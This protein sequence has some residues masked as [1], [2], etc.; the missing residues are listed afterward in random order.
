VCY[1]EV[2]V[3]ARNGNFMRYFFCEVAAGNPEHNTALYC[4]SSNVGEVNI[5]CQS[6]RVN[7]YNIASGIGREIRI[8]QRTEWQEL[9]II[10]LI[11]Q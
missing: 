11:T 6:Q 5:F 3:V 9:N 10:A 8:G 2:N 7:I 4:A 1:F